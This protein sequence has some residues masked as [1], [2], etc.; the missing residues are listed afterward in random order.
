MEVWEK[1]GPLGDRKSTK[2]LFAGLLPAPTALLAS[3][4]VGMGYTGIR[5]TGSG[6]M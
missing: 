6:V 5:G 3:R 2:K 4:V 1:K